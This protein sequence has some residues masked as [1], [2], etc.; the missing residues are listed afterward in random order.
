M[1]LEK[2]FPADAGVPGVGPFTATEKETLIE[3][4]VEGC[5]VHCG[6]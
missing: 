3:G 4:V 2:Q 5:T 1:V 6:Q